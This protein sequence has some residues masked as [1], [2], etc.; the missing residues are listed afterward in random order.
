MVFP[1]PCRSRMCFRLWIVE[2]RTL[3]CCSARPFK[4]YTMK[5]GAVPA[6]CMALLVCQPMGTSLEGTAGLGAC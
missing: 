2:Q 5:V 6:A 4:L 1:G 3:V